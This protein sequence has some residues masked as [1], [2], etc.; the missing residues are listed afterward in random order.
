V[1]ENSSGTVGSW[2][3]REEKIFRDCWQLGVEGGEDQLQGCSEI[4]EGTEMLC[5]FSKFY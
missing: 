5:I 1:T 4:S 3:L 2:G